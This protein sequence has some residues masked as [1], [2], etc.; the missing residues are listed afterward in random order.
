MERKS[1]MCWLNLSRLLKVAG[2]LP[3]Q[4]LQQATQED[5]ATGSGDA[6][7]YSI[8]SRNK[9]YYWQGDHRGRR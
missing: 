5:S 6:T 4:A 7:S 2:N 8:E 3:W 9:T 1:F